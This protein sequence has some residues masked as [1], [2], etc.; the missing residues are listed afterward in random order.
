MADGKYFGLS[1]PWIAKLNSDG[2]YDN[3]NKFKNGAAISTTITPQYSEAS[4]YADNK[5]DEYIKEFREADVE[6]GVNAM[7]AVAADVLFGH[8]VVDGEIIY[9][10]DDSANYVGY[11]FVPALADGVKKYRGVFLPKV[12]FTEGAE[13]YQ[14]KGDNI[15][16]VTPSLTGK[17]LPGATGTWRIK[18]EE[19]DTEAEAE[20]WI[21]SQF[22]AAS[23]YIFV[24]VSDTTGKNP[25][26]EGWYKLVNDA[27]VLATETTPDSGTTYYIRTLPA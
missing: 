21:L 12:K 2:T 10:A 6:L 23:P 4:L 20:A 26:E 27:Y 13:G 19:F 14:T 5:L 25:A 18:S 3:T 15:T 17:A 1:K 22:A 11:G 16:F 7:P 8:S 24:A 9:N